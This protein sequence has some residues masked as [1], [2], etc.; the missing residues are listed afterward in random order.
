VLFFTASKLGINYAR[1][2]SI[3]TSCNERPISL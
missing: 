2:G 1:I 3:I